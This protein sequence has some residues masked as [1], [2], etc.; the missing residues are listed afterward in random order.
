[1]G[2]KHACPLFQCKTFYYTGQQ[3]KLAFVLKEDTLFFKA[4]CYAGVPEKIVWD[5]RNHRLCLQDVQKCDIC[6][7]NC[8]STATSLIMAAHPSHLPSFPHRPLHC[9]CLSLLLVWDQPC[10]RVSRMGGDHEWDQELG[11]IEQNLGTQAPRPALRK[12]YMVACV[13]P[14]PSHRPLLNPFPHDNWGCWY[15]YFPPGIPGRMKCVGRQNNSITMPNICRILIQ[16]L[17]ILMMTP[18]GSEEGGGQHGLMWEKP[19]SWGV[20][21]LQQWKSWMVMT[22]ACPLGDATQSGTSFR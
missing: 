16:P 21:F 6:T 19:T 2:R 8:P 3:T 14:W 13:G 22:C 1:M 12:W 7:E 9:P 15:E 11:K 5:K 17:G 4:V 10:L 20:S 18:K